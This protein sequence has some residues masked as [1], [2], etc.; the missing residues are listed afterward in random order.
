MGSTAA[1]LPPYSCSTLRV[2][3]LSFGAA[4][5]TT[6]CQQVV[7]SGEFEGDVSFPCTHGRRLAAGTQERFNP[8]T[9]YNSLGEP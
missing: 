8:R 4:P 5:S 2:S 6:S 7:Y 1:L 9:W 3:P